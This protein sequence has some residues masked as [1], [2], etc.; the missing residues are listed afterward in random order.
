MIALLDVNTLV[1]LAWP[2]HVHHESAHRWFAAHRDGW[3]TTAV[4]ETGFVRVCAHDIVVREAVRPVDALAH[5]SRLRTAERHHYW[6]DN[7]ECVLGEHILPTRVL[8]HRQ[9]VDAHLVAL[10]IEYDGTVATFD[11]GIRSL[12]DRGH[13]QHVTLIP[14]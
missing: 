13:E 6:I 2:N 1:A 14:S 3:A 4:T 8:G 5:L 12:V 11:K 9:V 7:V 10:A